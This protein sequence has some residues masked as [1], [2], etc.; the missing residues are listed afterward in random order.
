MAKKKP[1]EGEN[2]DEVTQAEIVEY[3]ERALDAKDVSYG[4]VPLCREYFFNKRLVE[5]DL[6]MI[7]GDV[8]WDQIKY[9]DEKDQ[10]S[11]EEGAVWYQSEDCKGAMYVHSAAKLY[12]LVGANDEPRVH[13]RPKAFE[14]LRLVAGGEPRELVEWAIK[15]FKAG[16][17]IKKVQG[18]ISAGVRGKVEGVMDAKKATPKEK[19]KKTKP[20]STSSASKTTA[21]NTKKQVEKVTPAPSST[22]STAETTVVDASGN[23]D[24]EQLPAGKESLLDSSETDNDELLPGSDY[25]GS[26]AGG[27]VVEPPQ[28]P[29]DNT[30]PGGGEPPVPKKSSAPAW[31]KAS[32]AVRRKPEE[33]IRRI[34]GAHSAG[35]LFGHMAGKIIPETKSS[36]ATATPAPATTPKVSPKAATAPKGAKEDK[37]SDPA[38]KKEPLKTTRNE[39]VDVD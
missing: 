21:E 36:E 23:D 39:G 38:R 6:T 22:S 14:I 26:D 15:E 37:K 16:E 30:Q 18:Q 33:T 4:E 13:D 10:F 9:K 11:S 5:A 24:K 8:S 2:S 31:K 1:P 3:A 17:T 7:S 25:V 34:Q 19:I 29:T 12:G 28:V 20:A 35:S 27:G 32:S